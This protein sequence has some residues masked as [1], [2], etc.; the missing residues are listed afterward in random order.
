VQRGKIAAAAVA[1]VPVKWRLNGR[2]TLFTGLIEVEN[3]KRGT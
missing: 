3:S 2:A 1:E